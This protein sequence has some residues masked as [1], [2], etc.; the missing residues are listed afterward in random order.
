MLQQL[1]QKRTPKKVRFPGI[2]S[3]ARAL[4]IR[5]ESLWRYLSGDWEWPA[6]TK[7]RYELV[8]KQREKGRS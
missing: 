6:V 8:K 5:R 2:C 7:R 4:G 1:D 3:D